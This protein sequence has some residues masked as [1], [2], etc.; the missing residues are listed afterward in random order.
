MAE[1]VTACLEYGLDHD[2]TDM[3]AVM[4]EEHARKV[5]VGMGWSYER[6]GPSHAVGGSEVIALRLRLTSP[7][8][9][10]VRERTRQPHRLCREVLS[11]QSSRTAPLP[12]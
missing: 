11:S 8:L 12:A 3:L 6:C 5:V 1:L 7:A 9:S 4:T 10:K 2:I